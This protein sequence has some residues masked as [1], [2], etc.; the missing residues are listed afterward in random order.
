MKIQGTA[1][2]EPEIG[3][4]YNWGKVQKYGG[5]ETFLGKR[6]NKIV[7]ATLEAIKN[8]DAPEVMVVGDRPRN[9]K[10]AEEFCNQKGL[11][12]IF[13]KEATNKWRYWGKYEFER[14]TD[15]PLEI[16]KYQNDSNGKLT[17]VIFLKRAEGQSASCKY[18]DS[19]RMAANRTAALIV[20]YYLSR[21]D[22][23]ARK[24]LGFKSW[25]EAYAEIG[26]RLQIN[27]SSV[28]NMRDEFD[29]IHENKRRGWHQRPLRPSRA[30]VV[31][32]FCEMPE[33]EI[34]ILINGILN[35]KSYEVEEP[36]AQ[37]I[38]EIGSREAEKLR[39]NVFVNRG[40]TG[41]AAEEA[42]L[43][44]RQETLEFFP[45]DIS[46]KRDHGCGYDFEIDT[47]SK[48]TFIEIKGLDSD[49]GGVCFSSKEWEQATKL[50]TQYWLVL[51][52]NVSTKPSFQCIQSPAHKLSAKQSLLKRVV[53]IFNVSDKEL[54]RQSASNL[55]ATP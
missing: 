27:P 17:R 44:N 45:G 11:I 18:Q 35:E 41:R 9:R 37:I 46:D 29:P 54:K 39:R 23:T 5:E 7:C 48:K 20:C 52:R 51:V 22:A 33:P 15:D 26:K 3:K 8:P 53:S 40:T 38:H 31:N 34:L 36:L 6:G 4:V 25:N 49:T 55:K 10:R 42:F 14:Y 2:T 47:K 12:P 16:D 32:N 28:K 21:Y 19:G 1:Q 13:I 30:E 24:N 50:G 43:Q